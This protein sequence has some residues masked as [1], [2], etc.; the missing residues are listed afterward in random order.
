VK[1][2]CLIVDDEAI[3]RRGVEKYIE[4]ISFLKLEGSF[5]TA[6]QVS[7]HLSEK[8][9][10]LLFL[11]IQMP[12]LSGL[13]FIR[14]LSH[15]PLVIIVTA[16]PNFAMEG[17]ELDVLDYLVKPVSFERF[18]KACH[19]AKDYHTLINAPT[20]QTDYFFVKAD[21]RIEKI[22]IAKILFIEAVENYSTIYTSLKKYMT[23]LHGYAFLKVHRSYVVAL[24]K[25]ESLE[26]NIILISSYK[27]PVSRQLKDDVFKTILEGKYLKRE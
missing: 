3:A 5:E 9:A 1:I 2:T 25:I 12:Q 20:S 11:D 6:L 26:G 14:A 19:K 13:E 27:I 18:L 21:N 17:F 15:P 22:E 23:L 4:Q 8:T 24:N 10:D 16:Y 7:K